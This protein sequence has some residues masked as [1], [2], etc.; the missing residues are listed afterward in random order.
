[1]A[2]ATLNLQTASGH[3]VLAAAGKKILRPGGRAATQQLFG[4]ANFQPGDT[5][6]ELA[7]SF[8]YSAIAL[9][10]RYGVRVVGVEK[11]PESVARARKNVEAAG[12]ADQVEMIEGD[13]FRLEQIDRQFDYVL[14][15]AILTMQS[16]TGKAK[17]LQGVYDRLKPGGKFLSHE[18]LAQNHEAEIHRTLAQ[19]IRV[20]ATP[21]SIANWFALYETT[22]LQVNHYQTGVMGLLNRQQLLQDEGVIGTLQ[23]LWNVITNPALRSRILGMRRA[24]QQHK[25]DLGHIILCAER[26]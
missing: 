19:S 22:G 21:L 2:N 24:F 14:A 5:V 23:I 8:G 4:W 9:A 12:L 17:I 15:E 25:Q 11:N 20:N 26:S 16:P 1:M 13:I 7:S 18:L 3:Q 10:K 6:L